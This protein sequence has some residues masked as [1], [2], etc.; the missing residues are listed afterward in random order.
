MRSPFPAVSRGLSEWSP[1][2][3][4]LGTGP[5]YYQD[6]PQEARRLLAE[7]GVPKGFKILLHATNGTGAGP[8]VT[9]AAQLAQRDLKEVGI[10]AELK[11]EEYGAYMA[12]TYI[13]KFEGMALRPISNAW[14]PDSVLYGLFAPTSRATAAR[15]TTPRSRPCSR[16]NA[17]Q[18]TERRASRSSL[19]CSGILQSS[20]TMCTSTA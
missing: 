8:Q 4:E 20:S 10:E 17:G 15:S 12:T 19:T 18:R 7:A 13:G 14:E 6:D 3:D 9:D 16:N 11:I 5:R 1:R 2:I